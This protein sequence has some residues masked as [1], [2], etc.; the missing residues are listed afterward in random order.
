MAGNASMP[1]A[2]VV[3][4]NFFMRTPPYYF[5]NLLAYKPTGGESL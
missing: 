1:K 3:K 5:D 2:A 4:R